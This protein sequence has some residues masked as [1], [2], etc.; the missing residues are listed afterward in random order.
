MVIDQN[1]VVF[2]KLRYLKDA[3]GSRAYSSAGDEHERF[4]LAIKLV[5]DLDI[6]NPDS[7]FFA[8][9]DLLH[10]TLPITWPSDFDQT[11]S[12]LVRAVNTDESSSSL[13]FGL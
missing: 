7:A 13:L 5:V 4:T 1:L 6:I 11:L 10:G 2:G 9:C 3:P 8:W 12:N